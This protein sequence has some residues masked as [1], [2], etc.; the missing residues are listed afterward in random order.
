VKPTIPDKLMR[1]LNELVKDKFVEAYILEHNRPS[2]GNPYYYV[3]RPYL[4]VHWDVE[5]PKVQ[6]QEPVKALTIIKYYRNMEV[7]DLFSSADAEQIKLEKQ[8]EQE[9]E[10]VELRKLKESVA[11]IKTVIGSI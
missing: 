1:Q 11:N 8:F 9:M 10:L 2:L 5:A 4:S 6:P 7:S 3:S